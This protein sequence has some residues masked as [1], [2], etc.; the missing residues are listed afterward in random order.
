MSAVM[1]SNDRTARDITAGELTY[2]TSSVGSRSGKRRS[3]S[4]CI[5]TAAAPSVTITATTAAV[6]MP[7]R[8]AEALLEVTAGKYQHGGGDQNRDVDD[9]VGNRPQQIALLD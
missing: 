2:R 9:A 1:A 8:R 6:S 4:I 3:R 5:M 7:P